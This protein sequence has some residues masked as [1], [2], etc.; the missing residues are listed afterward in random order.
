MS[1]I[2]WRLAECEP[3]CEPF[4]GQ[5]N[6][7]TQRRTKT[8]SKD[9]VATSKRRGA[10]AEANV[11][12]MFRAFSERTR[13]RILHLLLHGEM[14]VGDLVTIL[15]TAQPRA[16]QHL[17]YLRNA[18]LVVVRKAGLWSYYS[19]APASSR[20]HQ[21]LLECLRH[22]FAEVP[23]LQADDC[24]AAALKKSGQCCSHPNR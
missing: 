3:F 18:G 4:H 22:C 20:F 9:D 12:D 5:I 10:H 23:E 14:C 11:D 6:M 15:Q 8:C 1:C 7:A 16:S 2:G 13:L 21:K 19:L 17:A 24:R